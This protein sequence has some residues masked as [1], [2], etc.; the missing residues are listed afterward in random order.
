MREKLGSGA[1]ERGYSHPLLFPA[2]QNKI[3]E[4]CKGLEPKRL[5]VV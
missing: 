5:P 3:T 4:N 2:M 1:L